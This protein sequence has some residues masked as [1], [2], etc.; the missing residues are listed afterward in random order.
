MKYYIHSACAF[1]D[2]CFCLDICFSSADFL[3]PFLG[4]FTS[5]FLAG[6][7]ELCAFFLVRILVVSPLSFSLSRKLRTRLAT[8]CVC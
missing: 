4:L 5:D 2:T 6:F 3:L 7:L 8:A 1:G